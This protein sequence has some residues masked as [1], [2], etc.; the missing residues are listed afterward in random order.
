VADA[1]AIVK[2]HDR[3][4]GQRTSSVET[5]WRDCFDFSFPLRGNG[6]GGATTTANAGQTKQADLTDSTAADSANT[7]A[8]NIVAGLTPANALWFELDVGEETQEEREWLDES[9]RLMWA[10]IHNSNYDAEAFEAA[11]DIVCAGQFALYIDED[12]E[13]GGYE[14]QQWPLSQV[15]VGSTRADR[16]VDIVHRKYPLTADAALRE[17]GKDALPERIRKALEDGKGDEEFM[18]L[19]AIYP[20]TPHVVGAKQAKNLPIASC[21]IEM[22]SKTMVRESGYHE[23]PVVVPRWLR[24]PDS[25]YAVGPMYAA[26]PDVRQINELKSLQMA[27]ADIAVSGM[28]AVKDDGVFNAKTAKIGP[29]KMLILADPDNIKPLST[30]ADFNVSDMLVKQLQ[31]SIRKTLMA[32][33][34]QPQDGPAMTATEVHVRVE[35][36]RKLLGPIY[37]RL[38]AEWLRPMIERCFGIAYRAGVFGP[39]PESL[40]DRSY[41][42]RYVS[43]LARAQKLEEV[44]AVESTFASVA[45]LA[46]IDPSVM[47]EL[48]PAEAIKIIVAGRGA[49][50]KIQRDQAAVQRVREER[51]AAQQQQMQQA[52]AIQAQAA[53]MEEAAKRAATA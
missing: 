25:L 24:V 53:G 36:I 47:D 27:A 3:M 4:V 49:P 22:G 6:L 9:A 5:V 30:G 44:M 51:Q 48:D 28:W 8:S 46:A 38:M 50:A 16:R 11:L 21:H 12:R 33:Q 13:N 17:F 14:F 42:V 2:L 43:P 29:R 10:N 52:G 23:M 40:R 35:M 41:T 7:L 31:A 18:F 34:L 26:L 1:S 32:D 15:W 39:A 37:G 20:R 45:Q 19:H